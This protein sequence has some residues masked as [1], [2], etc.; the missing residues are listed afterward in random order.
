MAEP[1]IPPDDSPFATL[2]PKAALASINR[3]IM[4]IEQGA[5]RYDIGDRSVWRGD[6][7]WMYPE[8]TRLEGLVAAV[9]AKERGG[10][11]FRRIVPC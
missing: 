2:S 8:R 3:A 9:V 1:V 10:P 7:R 6:L 4:T 11:R 5:Q